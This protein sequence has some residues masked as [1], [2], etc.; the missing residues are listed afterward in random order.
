VSVMPR[1][2]V[3]FDKDGITLGNQ[4]PSG[5]IAPEVVVK[6]EYLALVLVAECRFRG[7]PR[8]RRRRRGA[9][10]QPALIN[11]I[12][13]ALAADKEEYTLTRATLADRV[14]LVRSVLPRIRSALGEARSRRC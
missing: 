4:E 12:E 5:R 7:G 9:A 6:S 8:Q 14:G 10:Y 1:V 11:L 3:A 13:M 2:L